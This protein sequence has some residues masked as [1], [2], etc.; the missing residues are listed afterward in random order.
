MTFTVTKREARYAIVVQKATGTGTLTYKFITVTAL[1]RYYRMFGVRVVDTLIL[2]NKQ[3]RSFN[4]HLEEN[5][6]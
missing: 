3:W 5:Y 6:L 2:C 1:K 4:L